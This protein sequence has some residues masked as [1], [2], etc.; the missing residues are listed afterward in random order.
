MNSEKNQSLDA[1]KSKFVTLRQRFI[2]LYE[3]GATHDT[4]AQEL[5][6]AMPTVSLWRERAGLPPRRD[7]RGGAWWDERLIGDKSVIQMLKDLETPLCLNQGDIRSILGLITR[8][9]IEGWKIQGRS[10]QDMILAAVF[11]YIR[12][13]RPPINAYQFCASCNQAG[14]PIH[15]TRIRRISQ[16]LREAGVKVDSPKPEEI[17]KK[18]KY[19]LKKGLG[20]DDEVINEASSLIAQARS[21]SST[22]GKSP[23]S[24]AAS[25]IYL[26]S[27]GRTEGYITEGELSR[28]FGVT[29]VTIRNTNKVLRRFMRKE[30]HD[31]ME[32][33]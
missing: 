32:G 13:W 25:A 28:F 11:L 20:I 27:Q 14:Y 9:M 30:S 24:L 29:E 7:S 17:L 18:H 10:L 6:I 26:S 4:I 19:A 23:F 5:G 31:T 22:H 2:E 15:H 16:E 12:V 1:S 33:G 3:S 21:P 8:K